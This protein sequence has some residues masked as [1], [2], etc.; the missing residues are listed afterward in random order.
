MNAQSDCFEI[1]VSSSKDGSIQA[2][3]ITV[4]NNKVAKTKEIVEDTLLADYDRRGKLVGIEVLGPVKIRRIT[5]LV[6][7][8][9]RRRFARFVRQGAPGGMLLAG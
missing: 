3:Y 4:R 1:L 7:Q 6:E 5:P 2:V 8:A 9:Q